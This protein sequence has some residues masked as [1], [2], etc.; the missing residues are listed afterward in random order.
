MA[1]IKAQKVIR[2]EKGK[3][4]SGSA[5]IVDTVYVSTG[6]K[7]HS[8]QVVREKLGRILY[9]ILKDVPLRCQEGNVYTH[10]S[11]PII[12]TSLQ[13]EK[14]KEIEKRNPHKRKLQEYAF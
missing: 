2:D 4:T 13:R 7:N 3:I 11:S 12:A 8:K 14:R 9:L 1:F 6:K 5:A 10:F